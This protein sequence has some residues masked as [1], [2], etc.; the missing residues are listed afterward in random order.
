MCF[1]APAI[2]FAV[3]VRAQAYT[4]Y[5][6]IFEEIL[7]LTKWVWSGVWMAPLRFC[8]HGRF[9]CS[10]CLNYTKHSQ[11]KRITI[12]HSICVSCPILHICLLRRPGMCILTHSSPILRSTTRWDLT[13]LTPGIHISWR[14]YSKYCSEPFQ[15]PHLFKYL[16]LADLLSQKL[17]FWGGF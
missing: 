9:T 4:K 14:T 10:V 15:D 16:L 8:F 17:C 1:S 5:Y 7:D 13:F 11:L 2:D 3:L 12:F 6:T